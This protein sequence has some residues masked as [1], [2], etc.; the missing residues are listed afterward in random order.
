[1]GAMLGDFVR[2][3]K[4]LARYDPATR[5]GIRLHRHIDTTTDSLP[6]VS[7]LL[8]GLQ[9]PFRRYGGII[10]DLVFDHELAKRWDAYSDLPLDRFDAGVREMLAAND[11][12]VPERLRGFMR[13]ADRRGL[14]EAYRR[15]SEILHSLLGVGLR[16]SRA[17]PLHRVGEIWSDFQPRVETCFE[18]VFAEIQSDVETWLKSKSAI[19][20][21]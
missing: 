11:H 18:P 19:T 6:A 4:A 17:N 5:L 15:E 14:F 8:K 13:Y 7:D 1:M 10:I 20:G 9:P 3:N 21:S 2:G 16:L 12:L